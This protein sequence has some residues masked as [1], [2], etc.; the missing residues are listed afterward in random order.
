MRMRSRTVHPEF[1]KNVEL[2]EAEVAYGLPLRLAYEGLWGM[3]DREGRFEWKPRV[4]KL[5]ILPFDTVDFE[6]VLDALASAGFIWRYEVGGKLYGFI[7]TLLEWQSI[8]K[9]EAKSRLPAPP[10]KPPE[11]SGDRPG[12][13]GKR[14]RRV[15]PRRSRKNPVARANPQ[16]SPEIPR[17]PDE[18]SPTSTS[19]S[20]SASTSEELRVA[21]ANSNGRSGVALSISPP[22]NG[23]HPDEGSRAPP[24]AKPPNWVQSAHG[25]YL[26]HIGH[27]DFGR[28][29]RVL[30]PVV[31]KVGWEEVRPAWEW[32]CEFAPVESYLDRMEAGQ[33][34]QEEKPVKKFG[35]NTRPEAFVQNFT[36]YRARVA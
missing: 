31:G 18:S 15:T 34:R 1:Y 16:E 5:D 21:D 32:F 35:W 6:E 24:S 10:E 26:A 20:T 17:N 22:A 23:S 3:A 36:H 14:E 4:L 9:D 30:K 27:V 25:I 12:P 13:Q 33:V 7:P 11:I 2:Y 8:H 29:G 19:T 28:L